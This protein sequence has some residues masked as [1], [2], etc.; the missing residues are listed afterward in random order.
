[1]TCRHGVRNLISFAKA[2]AG[3]F[4][5]PGVKM[6][7]EEKI[8]GAARTR[9]KLEKLLGHVRKNDGTA[10]PAGEIRRPEP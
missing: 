2:E 9:P 10:G 6:L 8:S 1:M 3:D 7:F 5:R 4:R